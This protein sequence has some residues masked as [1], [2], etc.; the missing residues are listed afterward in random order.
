MTDAPERIWIDAWGGNWSPRSDGTQQYEYVRFDIHRSLALDVV[1][2]GGQ[3]SDAY[4]AQLKAEAMAKKLVDLIRE[5]RGD[6]ASYVDADW[7]EVTRNQYPPIQAK[8]KRDMELCW[9]IDAALAEYE[10]SK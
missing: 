4:E 9:M 3:A 6:L 7:P 5:A 1:T 10:A 8:W 2:A